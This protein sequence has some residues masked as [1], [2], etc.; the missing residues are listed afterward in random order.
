MYKGRHLSFCLFITT[1]LGIAL[2]MEMGSGGFLS[3]PN[4]PSLSTWTEAQG[5]NYPLP[6]CYLTAIFALLCLNHTH[7]HTQLDLSYIW[8]TLTHVVIHTHR[9][10]LWPLYL[11][12]PYV[13][14][15]NSWQVL[16]AV[17]TVIIM[18]SILIDLSLI[19]N[20][21]GLYRIVYR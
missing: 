11:V 4:P 13:H 21:I 2:C 15:N 19:S 10:I 3:T 14:N 5:E 20:P 9:P 1:V 8:F 16:T 6:S 7:T 18:L 17:G 12:S